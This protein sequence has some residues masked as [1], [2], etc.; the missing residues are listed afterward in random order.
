MS[1]VV[2]TA[3]SATCAPFDAPTS[4]VFR[5]TSDWPIVATKFHISHLHLLA[6]CEFC[7][8]SS[9]L[10]DCFVNIPWK[11]EVGINTIHSVIITA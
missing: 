8:E 6:S 11:I 10:F 2:G 4:F 7:K 5:V 9:V 3:V 1:N